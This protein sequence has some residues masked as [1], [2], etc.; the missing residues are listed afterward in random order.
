MKLSGLVPAALAVS[1]NGIKHEAEDN[2]E[3]EETDDENLIMK[4]EDFVSDGGDWFLKVQAVFRKRQRGCQPQAH[5]QQ[6]AGHDAWELC[7]KFSG[8]AYLPYRKYQ[9]LFASVEKRVGSR[10]SRRVA[11]TSSLPLDG[12]GGGGGPTRGKPRIPCYFTTMLTLPLAP[13]RQGRG[14]S[15]FPAEPFSPT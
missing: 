10:P 1:E 12:G 11:V 8:H 4:L 7:Y 9:N 3:Y 5:A 14:D 15:F 13:S 2:H 6:Q